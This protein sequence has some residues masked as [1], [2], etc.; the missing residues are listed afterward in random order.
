MKILCGC[1]LKLSGIISFTSAPVNDGAESTFTEI[2]NG[3]LTAPRSPRGAVS[4]VSTTVDQPARASVLIQSEPKLELDVLT[5][6]LDASRYPLRSK[7]L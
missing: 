2:I 6:S 7:T 4:H 1:E 3:A 5:R